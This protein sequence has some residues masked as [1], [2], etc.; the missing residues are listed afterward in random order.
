MQKLAHVAEYKKREVTE[1][2]KLMNEYQIIGVLN[3]ENLPAA[4]LVRMRKRIRENALMRMSKKSLIIRAIDQIK[5]KQG[6]TGLKDYLGG[7]PALIFTKENPFKIYKFIAQRKSPAPAKPGQT[8]PKDLIITAGAT[9]FAPGPI[10]SEFGQIGVKTGVEAG[11]VVVKQDTVVVKQGAKVSEKAASLLLRLGIQPMEVG[12]DLVAIYENNLIFGK[13]V[14]AVNE[15]KYIAE[16]TQ[17]AEWAV[18]LSVETSYATKET[19]EII[20]AKA[21]NESKNLAV[22]ASILIDEI[23]ELIISKAEREMMALKEEIKL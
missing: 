22:D 19:I 4:Q 10:I 13:D 18:N 14:L 2:V 5:D 20:I 8:A 23:I 7:M 9:P 6:I 3:M 1:L 15:G 21:Y 11:K 17:A 16:I 12:L